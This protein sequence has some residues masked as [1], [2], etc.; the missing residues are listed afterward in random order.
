VRRTVNVYDFRQAFVD[1]DRAENFSYA[2][3]EALFEYLV[4]LEED[5]GEEMELDVIGICCDFSEY[6]NIKEFQENYGDEYQT[7]EDVEERT[8]V[9]P[10][11]GDRFII[12]QF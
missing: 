10:V 2:G 8:T 1:Y 6:E 3:L 11:D 7:I 4:S 5:T 12:Q 9:I